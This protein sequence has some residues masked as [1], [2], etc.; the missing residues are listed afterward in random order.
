MSL[1]SFGECSV[2][3]ARLAELDDPLDH[4]SPTRC[5]ELVMQRILDAVRYRRTM[6]RARRTYRD[7]VDRGGR[8]WARE[9]LYERGRTR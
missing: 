4:G 9:V 2:I 1:A 7:A 6:H 5:E 3:D 8:T